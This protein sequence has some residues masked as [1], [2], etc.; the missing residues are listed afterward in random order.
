MSIKRRVSLLVKLYFSFCILSNSNVWGIVLHTLD[1]PNDPTF[2]QPAVHP[3]PSVLGRW[4]INASCVAISPNYII[5]TRHQGGGVNST[6]TFGGIEYKVAEVFVSG[7]ADLRIARIETPNGQPANLASSNYV[8]IYTST[9]EFNKSVVLGGFGKGRGGELTGEG[10]PYGYSWS[11]E[12]NS[13]FRWGANRIDG[14]AT[15]SA[16]D[17]SNPS[18]TYTSYSLKADFDAPGAA[19]AVACEAILA[20]HDSGGGWFIQD[21]TDHWTLAAINAYVTRQNQ[22]WYDDPSTS[23]TDPDTM[24]GI[25]ISSYAGWILDTAKSFAIPAG[26]ANWDGGVNVGDLGVLAANYGGTNKKWQDGDFNADGIVNVGD[27]GILAANYGGVNPTNLKGDNAMD[28]NTFIVPEPATCI[29]LL[30]GFAG[31]LFQF[32]SRHKSG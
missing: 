13:T 4:G 26:D 24:Y 31:I 18:I 25:R 3:E 5:T 15:V 8:S 23:P 7:N 11:G 20:V 19:T 32:R 27:L 29:F 2:G 6:V 17:P 9:S 16:Q 21:E 30:V 22:A 1:D 14:T 10:A 12:G 28:L